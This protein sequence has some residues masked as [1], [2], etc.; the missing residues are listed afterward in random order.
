MPLILSCH[1]DALRN[2]GLRILTIL[3]R[4]DHDIVENAIPEILNTMSQ[5]RAA[6][7]HNPSEPNPLVL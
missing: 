5:V 1:A 3:L 4:F 7:P 2:D 6:A